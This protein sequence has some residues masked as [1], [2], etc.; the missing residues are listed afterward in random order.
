[1][2]LSEEEQRILHEME[3]KLYE[4][5]RAFA[6]RLRSGGSRWSAERSLRWS[7]LLLAGG[8]ALLV[9]T[10]RSSLLLGTFGF[11][12]MLLASFLVERSVR[13][14]R[15]PHAGAPG[16]DGADGPPSDPVS[17]PVAQ[18]RHRPI[19][20]ELSVIASRVRSRLRRKP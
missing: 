6:Q 13:M 14:A 4:H 15:S 1:M 12:V 19:A 20:E 5:D 16:P 7:V 8:F 3:Q 10:F 17:A 11:L 9:L 2:P 18:A